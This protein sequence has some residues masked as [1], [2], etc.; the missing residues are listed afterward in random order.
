VESVAEK[1]I[2]PRHNQEDV[3]KV[4]A[5]VDPKALARTIGHALSASPNCTMRAIG[6][7]AVNQAVKALAIAR[8]DVAVRGQDLI[9]R[10]GMETTTDVDRPGTSGSNELSCVVFRVSAV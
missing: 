2:S 10:P 4:S 8:G 5:R 6:A 1:V 9:V 7:S 3:I